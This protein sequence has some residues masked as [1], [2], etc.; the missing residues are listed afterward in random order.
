VGRYRVAIAVR[1]ERSNALEFKAREAAIRKNEQFMSRLRS[2]ISVLALVMLL[3]P[4]LCSALPLSVISLSAA[5][6]ASAPCHQSPP[7]APMSPSNQKCCVA[8][9][10]PEAML[11]SA[12][13][14]SAPSIAAGPLFDPF[15][16]SSRQPNSSAYAASMFSSPPNLVPLRI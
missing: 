11:I 12:Q 10:Y 2:I 14:V 16:H 13:V 4:A 5:Q 6:P 3:L 1:A 15:S 9:H 7:A 8:A